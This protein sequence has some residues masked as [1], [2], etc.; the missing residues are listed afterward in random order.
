MDEWMDERLDGQWT[1][2]DEST[3]EEKKMGGGE[4]RFEEMDI[5][6]WTNN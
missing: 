2:R 6:R 1:N 5:Y 3:R 4:E